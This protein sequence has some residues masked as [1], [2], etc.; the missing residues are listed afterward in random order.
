[1][2][3]VLQEESAP[4]FTQ[5]I[6]GLTQQRESVWSGLK[7]EKK[8]KKW[9]YHIFSIYG[10]GGRDGVSSICSLLNKVDQFVSISDFVSE[11]YLQ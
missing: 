9:Y 4:V 6:A 3:P 2:S 5:S 10:P 1:M 7:S 8:K 11:Y